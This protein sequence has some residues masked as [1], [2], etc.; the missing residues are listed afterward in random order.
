MISL[1]RRPWGDMMIEKK[2]FSMLPA[3]LDDLEVKFSNGGRRKALL[4]TQM[5]TIALAK[6]IE[7]SATKISE[8]GK[9]FR[10]AKEAGNG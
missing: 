9:K 3:D 10:E 4:R 7:D 5:I 2:P 1:G 8:Y 6:R